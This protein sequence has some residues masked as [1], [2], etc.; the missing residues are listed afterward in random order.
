MKKQGENFKDDAPRLPITDYRLSTPNY[1]EHAILHTIKYFN[2]LRLPL[3]AT[4]L[5]QF[6]LV[7]D[8]SAPVRWEGH[9]LPSLHDVQ[10]A[11]GSSAWL[12]TS[13][14]HQWGYY[15]LKHRHELVPA[16]LH[17]HATAQQKWKILR[18]TTAALAWVPFIELLAVSGSTALYNTKPSSDF[19]ILVVTRAGRIWTVRLLLL[20]M[21]HL[22][23]RRRKHWDEAAPDKLCFNHYVT[24]RSLAIA[25]EI[26]NEYTAV[27][28]THLVLLWGA[29]SYQRF[30]AA[31]VGWL[32]RMCMYRDPIN[33]WTL[34][35]HPVGGVAVL[36]KRQLEL[37][38]LEPIGDTVESLV[39]TLQQRIIARHTTPSHHGR[40]VVSAGELA[41]HPHSKMTGILKQF[42]QEAGQQSLL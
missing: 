34:H 14:D 27:L 1:L 36:L 37:L 24:S 3:T 23:G 42:S 11:L 30:M 38:L 16:W 22:L 17:R 2:V 6:L 29:A 12:N 15:F 28:Y 39:G 21:A 18:R 32:K 35:A 7:P 13:I 40:V 26:R 5:W 31:N 33:D 19:D 9:A 25:P 4:Q 10:N 20:L 8:S 41:F